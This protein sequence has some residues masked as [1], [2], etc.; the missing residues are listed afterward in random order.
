MQLAVATNNQHKLIEIKN[1]LNPLGIQVLSPKDL[2]ILDFLPLETGQTFCE[3]AKIKS[4]ELYSQTKL[5]SLADDSGLIVL[6]LNYEPGVYSARYGGENL[7]DKERCKLILEKMKSVSNREAYFE[8]C[9]CYTKSSG[10]CI[11]FSGTVMGEIGT[12]YMLGREFGYDPIFFYPPKGCYFSEI[13]EEEKN[14]ISHRGKA[15]KKFIEYLMTQPP[16]TIS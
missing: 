2:G 11:F 3:N 9:L 1:Y 8:C 16:Q 6:G 7:T 12:E 15:L 5:P 14:L 10:E 13:S 4:Y